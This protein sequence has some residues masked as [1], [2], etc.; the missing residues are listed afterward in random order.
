MVLDKFL[1]SSE[2]AHCLAVLQVGH[3]L[4]RHSE[5][6]AQR[7]KHGLDIFKPYH[8][9]KTLTYEQQGKNW[10]RTTERFY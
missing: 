7:L 9:S 4:F 10:V 1:E 5:I 3:T 8:G 2:R 6:E